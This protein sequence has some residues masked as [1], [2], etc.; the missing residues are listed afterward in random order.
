MHLK[1]RWVAAVALFALVG[2]LA[3]CGGGNDN[4]QAGGSA[5][6]KVEV[7]SWWTGGGEAKGLEAMIADFKK[8]NPNIEFV[9]A[10]VAGGSGTNAKAVLASRLQAN[11]PPDSFQ[12]HAGAELM[13]YIKAGQLEP[14]DSLYDQLKLRD[15]FPQQLIDQITFEGHVYSVPVNIHRANVLWFSPKVLKEAGIAKPPATIQEFIT[16]LKQVKDKTGKIPLS[17]GAQWTA[18]HL[19]DA[20]MLGDLG[21][22]GWNALWKQGADWKSPQVTRALGDYNTI[23]QYTNTEAASTDWQLAAKDVVDGKAAFNIMGDWAAGYFKELGKTPKVDY[24][25][26][27]SPGTDGAYQWLSDSFTL[28][29]GAPHRDAAVAWLTE[30]ASRQG[31]DLFNPQKG[32]IPARKDA[33]TGL[34]KDYLAWALEQWQSGK[35]AGSMWHGVTAN[36]AWHTNIDT[37]VGLFLKNKDVANF[38]KSLVDAAT[39]GLAQ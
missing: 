25:W 2:L 28:P 18:A 29:K 39:S 27:A 36:N 9:N 22:D 16:D 17:L 34:Y 32:S 5:A 13:D 38:Q 24:D 10:A 37:S 20:V 14:L 1:R 15:A 7:F 26:A 8:N 30:A 3:S 12:G 21:V 4:Q 33:D 6:D 31:Q 19:L 23:L 35:L 11:Q